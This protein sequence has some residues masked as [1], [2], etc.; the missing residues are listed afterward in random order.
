MAHDH[1]LIF[2]TMGENKMKRIKSLI[3]VGAFAL[4]VMALPAVASAQWQGRNDD[5]YRNGR[6]ANIR[7]NVMSL[8]NRARTFD[9]QVSGIDNRRDRR[10]DRY[11]RID[12]LDRLSTQFKNAAENLADEFGRG[13]NMGNSRDEAQ[14][15]LMLGS[16][17]DQ[18]L[19]D[20]RNGR[21]VNRAVLQSQWNQIERDLQTIAR[22]YGMN[23]NSRNNRSRFPF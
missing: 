16:Q 9:R 3:A 7:G 22:A 1:C 18:V 5:F 15:V 11:D 2:W 19:G 23:Y 17:I 21:N 12:T 8:Q 14:R 13:R 20:T 6:L 10:N 4:A